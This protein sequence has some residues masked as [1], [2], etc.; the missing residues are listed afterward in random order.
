MKTKLILSLLLVFV[1]ASCKKEALHYDSNYDLVEATKTTLTVRGQIS[2]P[3]HTPIVEFGF[4][5]SEVSNPTASDSHYSITDC[6]ESSVYSLTHTLE[7]LKPETEYHIR[8]YAVIDSEY[9]YGDDFCVKTLAN[10]LF[11]VGQ[12][13][14]V[15]FSKG[16][17]QYQASTDT[18]RFAEHPWDFIG[19]SE[20]DQYGYTYGTVNGS[21]NHLI[22]PNYDGWIDLFGWGTSGQNHGAVCYQPWSTSTNDLDYSAYGNT[23][24]NLYDWD[25]HA[26]WGINP[27]NNGG[28]QPN[29]WRTLSEKEWHYLLRKRETTSNIRFV[30][31]FIKDDD[32][33]ITGTIILPDDWDNSI[34][35]LIGEPFSSNI[36]SLEDWQL[37]EENGAVLLPFTGER[38]GTSVSHCYNYSAYWTSTHVSWIGGDSDYDAFCVQFAD[39]IDYYYGMPRHTGLAVRLVQDYL[40]NTSG[41]T[42]TR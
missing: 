32:I 22:S 12:N 20:P 8:V 18:W 2:F 9:L 21:S 40:H 5:W 31:A 11:T 17:L 29:T 38:H 3:K 36:L 27:I 16:N 39:G 19:Y 33:N 30:I 13:Q 7:R 37:L 25:N 41:N 4:C 35:H 26:D 6:G 34:Y 28:N 24:D 1:F 23:Y 42:K 15:S 14:W 10:G